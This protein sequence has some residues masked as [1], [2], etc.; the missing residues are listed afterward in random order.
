MQHRES[1]TVRCGTSDQDDTA[2]GPWAEAGGP[3]RAAWVRIGRLGQAQS[4]D[5]GARPELR[6][7]L[8]NSLYSRLAHPCL[9]GGEPPGEAPHDGLKNAAQ[10]LR[11]ILCLHPGRWSD[12]AAA[13]LHPAY[14]RHLSRWQK[15]IASMLLCRGIGLL[16]PLPSQTRHS[17]STASITHQ[18]RTLTG[19]QLSGVQFDRF[20][21]LMPILDCNLHVAGHPASGTLS[22]VNT[23]THQTQADP[24]RGTVVYP[25]PDQ[26][27]TWTLLWV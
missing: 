2:Q 10:L 20:A 5:F 13:S 18:S 27:E 25:G 24:A 9:G 6:Y 22:L 21:G 16:C 3:A 7:T 1:K 11:S 19:M 15:S 26:I 17:V 12:S 4:P 23:P 8:I 14:L